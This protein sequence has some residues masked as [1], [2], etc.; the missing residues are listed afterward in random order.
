M[1]VE[2]TRQLLGEKI[3]DLTDE[4]VL[5]LIEKTSKT[6]DA[7]FALSVKQAIAKQNRKVLL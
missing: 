2:R 1:T 6:I 4:Q 5:S 7:I 3:K